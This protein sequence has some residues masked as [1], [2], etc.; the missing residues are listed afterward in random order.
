MRKQISTITIGIAIILSLIS[1]NEKKTE[2]KS[3]NVTNEI[4]EKTQDFMYKKDK[5][6]IALT[7]QNIANKV[8]GKLDFMPYEKDS[9]LGTIT[10]VQFKGDTLFAIY[11]SM[12]EGTQSECEIAFLKKGD[13]YILSNDIFGENNYQYNSDYTKGKF[14]NKHIIK[15]DGETLERIKTI[16]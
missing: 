11:N 9:R 13:S 15:F 8:S 6:T 3:Q 10:D 1:C 5:D 2:E 16:K 7:L 4:T 14:K 12:Q